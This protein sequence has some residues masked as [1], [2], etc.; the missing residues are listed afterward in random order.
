QLFDAIDHLDASLAE[1][2]ASLSRVIAD[3]KQDLAAARALP[4]EAEPQLQQSMAETAA[5]L[6]SAAS[7]KDPLTTLATLQASNAR[8]DIVLEAAR[9]KHE[10]VQAAKRSLDH[11][12]ATARSE[13]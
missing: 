13:I 8:L 6:A 11:A 12:I 4:A 1:A 5:A 2:T 9:Q 10:H 3:T 7:T